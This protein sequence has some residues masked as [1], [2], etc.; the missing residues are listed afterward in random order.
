MHGVRFA[1]AYIDVSAD[2]FIPGVKLR[3]CLIRQFYDFFGP[4][5]Q[6]HAF[7]GKYDPAVSLSPDQKLCSKFVLQFHQLAGERG[8]CDM[9]IFGGSGDT[10]FSRHRQKITQNSDFHKYILPPVKSIAVYL[11][12]RQV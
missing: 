4:S 5:A 11:H 8:L 3:F 6:Q 10:L 7:V 12:A 2:D 1:A 9:Q